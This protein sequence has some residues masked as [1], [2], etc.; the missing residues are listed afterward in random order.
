MEA[1]NRDAIAICL[2]IAG[3]VAGHLVFFLLAAQGFY[4]LAVPG[5]FVGLAAG[6]VKTRSIGVAVACAL[7]ALGAGLITQY[8]FMPSA[9]IEGFGHFLIHVFDLQPVTLFMIG[10]G[11]FAGFWVPFRRRERRRAQP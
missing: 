3:G 8:R 6:L 1:R 11:A 10:L 2:A 4:G 9:A 5:G 7:L